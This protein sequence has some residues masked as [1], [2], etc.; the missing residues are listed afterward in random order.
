MFGREHALPIG[1][2]GA[3]ARA[4]SSHTTT[5]AEQFFCPPAIIDFGEVQR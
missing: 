4:I 5:A 3:A 2:A 1:R